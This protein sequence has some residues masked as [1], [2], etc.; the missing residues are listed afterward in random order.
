M[1]IDRFSR[2]LRSDEAAAR[3]GNDPNRRV[4]S[5][6]LRRARRARRARPLT[7]KPARRRTLGPRRRIC[8]ST[9][10]REIR[11]A[12]SSAP[13]TDTRRRVDARRRRR[14][15]RIVRRLCTAVRPERACR[16]ARWAAPPRR[17][18]RR[19]RARSAACASR[20]RATFGSCG[21]AREA[22]EERACRR[23]A[24]LGRRSPLADGRHAAG[25]RRSEGAAAA[26]LPARAA[27]RRR[28]HEAPLLLPRDARA[29]QGPPRAPT[30]RVLP[31]THRRVASLNV[32]ARRRV[33]LRR[34]R[35]FADAARAQR[36]ARARSDGSE[37][38]SDARPMRDAPR[39]AR[40]RR[41]RWRAPP[42]SPRDE[43]PPAAA[44]CFGL[45][46]SSSIARSVRVA[47]HLPARRGPAGHGTVRRFR[48]ARVGAPHLAMA[49][50]H[51]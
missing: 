23:S 25:G 7:A 29:A 3:G 45:P 12:G 10:L 42:R 1:D 14:A 32:A 16:S 33:G 34:R 37:A 30:P 48:A 50:V 47:L 44:A 4:S 27:R 22:A 15:R 19:R 31:P 11:H 46:S 24:S 20:A 35:V 8:I 36:P 6:H 38:T 40:G 41:R 26:R 2:G 13:P 43:A 17:R 28:G 9:L 49:P 18:R 5:G 39:L 21:V 51:P